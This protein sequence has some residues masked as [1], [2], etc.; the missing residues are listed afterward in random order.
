MSV[1]TVRVCD[2]PATT[3]SIPIPA[4]CPTCSSAWWEF[5][6]EWECLKR[7]KKK[8]K[9]SCFL[10]MLQ[11]S[12]T[13]YLQRNKQSAF[14]TALQPKVEEVKFLVSAAKRHE[15]PSSTQLLPRWERLYYKCGRPKILEPWLPSSSVTH[16]VEITYLE[17]QRKEIQNEQR[18]PPGPNPKIVA[19]IVCQVKSSS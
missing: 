3:H 18:L 14:P 15:L 2:F 12:F 10:I 16:R 1:T 5:Y 13:V 6:S 17:R 8:K 11:S 19:T 7:F 9:S 4:S